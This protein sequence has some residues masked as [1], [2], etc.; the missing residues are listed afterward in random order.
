MISIRGGLNPT[1]FIGLST[2]SFAFVCCVIAWIGGRGFPALRRFAAMLAVLEAALLLDMAFSGRWLLHD[3]LESEAH[4][5][6]L[7]DLRAGLQSAALCFL[8]GCIAAGIAWTLW[9]LR[10]EPGASLAACGGILSLGTW[11]VEVVSLHAVDRVLYRTFDGVMCVTLIW[12]VGA[13]MTGAGILWEMLAV[14]AHVRWDDEGR[15]N[16]D[17][18]GDLR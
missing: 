5:R 2:C 12:I 1:Q 7:Y 13:L 8:G 6:D 17:Q 16:L 3:W 11:C 14:R 9:R 18:H 4:A 15:V 10:G